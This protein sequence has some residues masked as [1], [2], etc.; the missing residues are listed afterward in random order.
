VQYSTAIPQGPGGEGLAEISKPAETLSLLLSSRDDHEA[1]DASLVKAMGAQRERL[2]KQNDD[3]S[4]ELCRLRES[5]AAQKAEMRRLQADNLRLYEKV[6]YLKS[7]PA[8][9]GDLEGGGSGSI[10]EEATEGRYSKM[11]EEK[12]NP[13]AA[14]TKRERARKYASLSPA[15]KLLLNVSSF[16][17]TNRHARM[18]VCGYVV[19]LHLL[20][21]LTTYSVTHRTQRSWY[22][23]QY[24][25]LDCHPKRLT[26]T[27]R[28]NK[29]LPWIHSIYMK[30]NG[31]K[32]SM[33]HP[34]VNVVNTPQ[35]I[36]L[37]TSDVPV[38]ASAIHNGPLS[39]SVHAY[40]ARALLVLLILTQRI[41]KGSFHRRD[42]CHCQICRLQSRRGCER[43][44]A[45]YASR[46]TSRGLRSP[47]IRSAALR[48]V[49]LSRR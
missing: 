13:F 14:F 24:L 9:G 23:Q 38:T 3:L 5:A 18:F 41:F 1:E 7:T 33:T 45:L 36:R 22:S 31:R 17:L 25:F 2:R 42:T 26:N 43:T 19:C 35:W 29:H 15:E 39:V 34:S 46:W 49:R 6:K 44:S 8:G 37:Q 47:T 16:I 20:V 27:L 48:D 21:T 12:M 4:S 30:F 32:R 28:Y 10:A 11:Y 40:S